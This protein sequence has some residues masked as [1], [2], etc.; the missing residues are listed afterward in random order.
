MKAIALILLFVIQLSMVDAHADEVSGNVKG[1][2]INTR[3]VIHAVRLKSKPQVVD[4]RWAATLYWQES[5]S[6]SDPP[7]LHD[8]TEKDLPCWIPLYL[9]DVNA[10]GLADGWATWIRQCIGLQAIRFSKFL[11]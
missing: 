3:E 10:T 5:I 6:D 11:P 8:I 4:K 7:E 9:S 1:Y 2:L